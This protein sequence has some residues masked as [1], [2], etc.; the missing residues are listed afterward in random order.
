M[1]L[2]TWTAF[3]A[4][5]TLIFCNSTFAKDYKNAGAANI[6]LGPEERGYLKALQDF[7]RDF[8]PRAA[9][10]DVKVSSPTL[11]RGYALRGPNAYA[12]Y[13][14]A[15][16]DH[17]NPTTGISITIEPQSGGTATWISPATGQ[18][19][20]RQRVSAGSQNLQVPAFTTDIA[21]KIVEVARN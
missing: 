15:Y 2:R 5:G 4:E 21:L 8:D 16:T 1:R 12:A 14:H 18:V 19:L 6:Y 17:K 13:I 11:V 9:I 20:G 3:F 7:T 10:A